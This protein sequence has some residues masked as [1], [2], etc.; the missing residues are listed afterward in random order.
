MNSS[1]ECSKCHDK[2]DLK[3]FNVDKRTEDGREGVCKDCR[4]RARHM[5]AV[6]GSQKTRA[7]RKRALSAP[8]GMRR[9]D[10]AKVVITEPIEPEQPKQEDDVQ[11]FAEVKKKHNTYFN[12]SY[13]PHLEGF[14]VQLRTPRY[15]KEGKCLRS[16]LLEVLSLPS[17]SEA[18]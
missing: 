17:V 1:K 2:K 6:K 12:V 4:L 3:F 10:A 7:E 14:S 8:V 18:I 15:H 5:R 9:V 13:H 11:L 16:L